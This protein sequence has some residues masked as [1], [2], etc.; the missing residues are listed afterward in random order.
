[1]TPLKLT[2]FALAYATYILV[3]LVPVAITVIWMR[4]KKN[5]DTTPNVAPPAHV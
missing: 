2:L 3:M 1:M 4:R 5:N